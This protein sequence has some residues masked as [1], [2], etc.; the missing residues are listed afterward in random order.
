MAARM[1][2]FKLLQEL[3]GFA[4]VTNRQPPPRSPGLFLAQLRAL[5]S[6]EGLRKRKLNITIGDQEHL[7]TPHRVKINHLKRD[8]DTS[9][10]LPPL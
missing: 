1:K 8:P 5:G 3:R 9:A 4:D 10:T 2:I 7:D 6:Q